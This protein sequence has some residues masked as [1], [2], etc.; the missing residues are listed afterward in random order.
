[1]NGGRYHSQTLAVNELARTSWR[2][3]CMGRC[4][5]TSRNRALRPEALYLHTSRATLSVGLQS[6]NLQEFP[7][8]WSHDHGAVV[9]SGFPSSE[10][11][12]DPA[13]P[14]KFAQNPAGLAT[15]SKNDRHVT[16]P[17]LNTTMKQTLTCFCISATG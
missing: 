2:R 7:P 5:L 15:F 16:V 12:R 10:A 13:G 3:V 17:S 4:C 1:M 14:V 8:P 6:R 11:G 9:S